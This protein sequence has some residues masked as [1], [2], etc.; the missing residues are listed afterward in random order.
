MELDSPCAHATTST[1]WLHRHVSHTFRGMISDSWADISPPQRTR[2][3]S[4]RERC[5][6]LSEFSTKLHIAL[7]VV[8]RGKTEDLINRQVVSPGTHP[9]PD[10]GGRDAM[11][12]FRFVGQTLRP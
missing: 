11:R 12:F 2:P 8:L 4:F 5:P 9:V 6:Q 10:R 3:Q 1:N 7:R